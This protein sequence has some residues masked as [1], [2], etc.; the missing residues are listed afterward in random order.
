MLTHLSK[1]SRVSAPAA[2]PAVSPSKRSP[3]KPLALSCYL[4]GQGF[5]YTSI[6]IHQQSCRTRFLRQRNAMPDPPE[7]PLPSQACVWRRGGMDK[8]AMALDGYV[9]TGV[10]RSRVDATAWAV[11]LA[12]RLRSSNHGSWWVSGTSLP[13][14]VIALR[15]MTT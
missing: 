5:G 7:Q 6:G 1:G 2:S 15:F 4:C 13:A 10:L 8:R 9:T 12:G 14:V 11:W 3:A